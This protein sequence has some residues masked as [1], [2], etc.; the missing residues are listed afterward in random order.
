MYKAVAQIEITIQ[1]KVE[2]RIHENKSQNQYIAVFSHNV[3][4]VHPGTEV[5]FVVKHNFHRIPCT[6]EMPTIVDRNQ[7]ALGRIAIQ[8]QV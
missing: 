4:P 8:T 2:V 3:D 1:D 7:L 6:V 5:V